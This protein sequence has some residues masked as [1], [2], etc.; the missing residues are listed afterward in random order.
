MDWNASWP[1]SASFCSASAGKSPGTER[2]KRSKISWMILPRS[3]AAGSASNGSNGLSPRMCR[4]YMAYG[5][6][7]QDSI[8]VTD[9]LRGLACNGGRG[10]G[11]WIGRG[12]SGLSSARSQCSHFVDWWFNWSRPEAINTACKRANQRDGTVGEPPAFSDRV[13][14]TFLRADHCGKVMGREADTPFRQRQ[15]ERC[16]H[17]SAK[18][19]IGVRIAWPVSLIH[20]AKNEKVRILQAR[21]Q[22]P[23]NVQPR[24]PSIA[25]TH[26]TTG[27]QRR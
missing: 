14:R 24:M 6:R 21:F 17:R 26:D 11:G 19:G 13:T 4:A 15:S 22:R 27:H 18:P 1:I 8:C 25:G 20:T 9:N 7:I 10:A 3:A 23:P 16:L 2:M 12:P 5:S